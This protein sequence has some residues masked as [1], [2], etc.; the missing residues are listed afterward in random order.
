MQLARTLAVP[1]VCWVWPIA[2]IRQAGFCFGKGLGDAL[3]LRFR[4][5]GHPLDLVGRP[6]LDFVADLVHAVDALLDELLVLPA[7]LEDVPEHPVKH[8]D[9]GAGAYTHKV[10]CVCSRARHARIDDDHIRAVELLAFEHVL[11]RHRMRFG[12]VAAQDQHGLG[13]ADIVEAV[14]H[15]AVAPGIGQAGD[16]GGMAD[17]RCVIDVVGAPERRQLAEDVGILVGEFGGAEPV[18]RIRPGFF[19]DRDEFVADLIDGR[20]PAHADPV[21]VEQLHRIFQPAVADARLHVPRRP[22][23]NAS[24]D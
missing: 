6:L 2:Q 19:A 13:V 7:I 10:G 5:A 20:V 18:D 3:E 15:R 1:T 9:V 16:G 8:R 23:R 21:A 24:R 17:A 4:N 22:W 11:Q 14:G 12:R